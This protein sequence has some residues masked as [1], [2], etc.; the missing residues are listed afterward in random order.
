MK[1]HAHHKLAMLLA[2]TGFIA[3]FAA[4]TASA[5]DNKTLEERVSRI[6]KILETLV[7]AQAAAKPASTA[8]AA[9]A[10][11]AQPP[12]DAYK[13][14]LWL[15]LWEARADQVNKNT[16]IPG[17]NATW[18][19]LGSLVVTKQ[20]FSPGDFKDDPDY[21]KYY[22]QPLYFGWE[23]YLKITK[24]GVHTIIVEVENTKAKEKYVYVSSFAVYLEGNRIAL[25]GQDENTGG[26]TPR[27]SESNPIMAVSAEVELDP[28]MYRLQLPL[29]VLR[30]PKDPHTGLLNRYDALTLTI[31]LKEPGERR[32]RVLTDADLFHKD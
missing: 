13:K 1:T 25:A 29:D 3:P 2:L 22:S 21:A 9:P 11:S 23:G 18:S 27:L 30:D 20:P 12:A 31:K 4:T 6:E 24:P 10:A 14:G 15:N 28:G 16:K 8:A 17:D 26:N 7:A 19:P 32:P 5:Q